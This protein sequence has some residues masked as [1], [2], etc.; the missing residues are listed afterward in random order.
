MCGFAGFSDYGDS[1][2]DERY[3][4]MALARR[5]AGRIAHRG[6]DDRGE[7]VSNHVALSHVRLSVIDPEK[8]V[9]PM[10]KTAA[11]H[12]YTIAYNG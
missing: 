9:Q 5:M 3:L 7:H 11:G 4:W 2:R 8:G 10:T 12:S 6:P 1:L